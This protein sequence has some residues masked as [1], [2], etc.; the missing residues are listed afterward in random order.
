MKIHLI[1]APEPLR[2][3]EDLSARCGDILSHGEPHFMCLGD[4]HGVIYPLGVCA[5]C[6]TTAPP[7]W[8]RR[9][10]Y[11]MSE[12]KEVSRDPSP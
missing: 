6:V 5:R 12:A 7:V 1:D 3:Y 10:E 11:Q 2:S 8:Q 9:F 4:S